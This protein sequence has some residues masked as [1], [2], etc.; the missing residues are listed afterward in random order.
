MVAAAFTSSVTLADDFVINEGL[1]D[2]LVIFSAIIS[3]VASEAVSMPLSVIA[4][5]T[6]S[7]PLLTDVKQSSK[8]LLTVFKLLFNFIKLNS[9]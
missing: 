1:A 8:L 4:D 6:N 5:A 3:K 2:M 9:S 7:F